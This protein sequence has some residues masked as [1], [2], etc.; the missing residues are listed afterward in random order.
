MSAIVFIK[1]TSREGR[2]FSMHTMLEGDFLN[3]KF[4]AFSG[5]LVLVSSHG[6]NSS[7]PISKTVLQTLQHRREGDASH[8]FNT[9]LNVL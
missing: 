8:F 2:N 3:L 5:I 9:L 7:T 6:S 1:F 4:L